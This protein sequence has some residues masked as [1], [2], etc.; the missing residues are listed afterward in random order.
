[1]SNSMVRA[2]L[3]ASVAWTAPPVSRQSRNEST[4]P[5]ASSPASARLRAPGTLSSSQAILVAEKYGSIL[6]PVR[7]LTSES[8]PASE[9][10]AQA[11]AVRRSCQTM[12]RWIACPVL[13]SQTSVVSRWLVMPIAAISLPS[14][15]AFAIASRQV[16][17][18]LSQRSSGSC[19]TQP[20]AGK[21]WGN[22][23]C[24]VATTRSVAS[25]RIARDEVVP[26]SI[27]RI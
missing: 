26:W 5:K 15:P 2:A 24:A 6:R 17:S 4:V 23:R 10:L 20:E 8:S 3:V 12:A 7:S 27:A 19:S 25:N 9:S 22:S 16:A 1:M 13:R 21:C 18:T 11:A 14:I